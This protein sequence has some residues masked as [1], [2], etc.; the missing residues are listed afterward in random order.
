[1]Q[2][3]FLQECRSD[4]CSLK[5]AWAV[6]SEHIVVVKPVSEVTTWYCDHLSI[7]LNTLKD[8]NTVDSEGHYHNSFFF[9]IADTIYTGI[10]HM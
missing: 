7:K 4:Q 10:K 2:T 1:M 9:N 3:L 6:G 8:S 5:T